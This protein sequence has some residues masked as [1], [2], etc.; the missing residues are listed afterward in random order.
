M[1]RVTKPGG[2]ICH[3]QLDSE[4]SD[5]RNASAE[6]QLC[7]YAS[8]AGRRTRSA[9]AIWPQYMISESPRR[10]WSSRQAHLIPTRRCST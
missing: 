1:V 5:V 7:V 2:R 3:G 4:R 6:N 8:T 10:C 9:N